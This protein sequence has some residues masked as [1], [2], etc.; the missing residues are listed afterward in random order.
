MDKSNLI[1]FL[2][3]AA[4]FSAAIFI[5]VMAQELGASPFAIG[6]ILAAYN[7]AFFAANYLFGVLADRVCLRRMIQF[8]L[9]AAAV[10]FLLQ[11]CAHDL[12]GLAL[13]RSLAG[14][15]AG[16]FPAALAVYA[17][18]ARAGKMGQ[19]A[20]YTSLGWGFGAVAAGV[21]G[22][23][24]LIFGLSAA[25]LLIAFLASLSLPEIC[26][27]ERAP[28]FPW[29]LV[30]KNLRVYLPY[31][32]RAVGAQ[33]SWSIF[34]LYLI[35]T[36]A[37]KL[38]VGLTYFIN[39]GAQFL[40]MQRVE[41]VH[42]LFLINIG[43]LASVLTFMLYAL[44]PHIG[45]VMVVQVLLALAFSTLQVGAQQE[46]LR[47]N[48]EKATVIGLLNSISNFTAVIGPFLAGAILNQWDFAAVMWF[49]A[50]VSFAGLVAF[51]SVLE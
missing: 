35:F 21:I 7:L 38:L 27:E 15:A 1:Q 24:N 22:S 32:L 39:L 16:T 44:F 6:A 13:V 26:Q 8:G 46:L 30:R 17:Y 33:T 18:Q 20:A 12:S 5:P 51:T 40:L 2:T 23:Y 9:L 3:N 36:G 31:F 11:L 29:R 34:P 47:N 50:V 49:S 42:N 45:V 48:R 41:R 10:I 37:D 14:F 25:M 19:F 43:L 4:L 28:F